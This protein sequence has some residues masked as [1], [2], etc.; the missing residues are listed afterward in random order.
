MRDHYGGRAAPSENKW[1]MAPEFALAQLELERSH[2][3]S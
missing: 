3:M 2:A 1:T